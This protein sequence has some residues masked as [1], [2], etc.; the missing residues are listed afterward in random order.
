MAMGTYVLYYS[1]LDRGATMFGYVRP[2]KSELKIKTF[3]LYRTAYCGLC[4]TVKVHYGQWPRLL[5][6]YDLTFL[7]LLIQSLVETEPTFVDK[8]CVL[9]PKK[10]RPVMIDDQIFIYG[11][12]ILM[13]LTYLKRLDDRQDEGHRLIKG[14][15]LR[16]YHK[17]YLSA[18]QKHHALACRLE[19][20]YQNLVQ[21]EAANESI[22]SARLFG[23]CIG[24]IFDNLAVTFSLDPL[25]QRALEQAGKWLGEW[26]YWID[27]VDD[28][29]EDLKR[30]RP[31][32]L[33]QIC[34]SD[35]AAAGGER[36]VDVVLSE[37]YQEIA[38]RC[39]PLNRHLVAL[40]TK[41]DQ[42]FALLP[43]CQHAELIYNIIVQGL[44]AVRQSVFLNERLE[45]L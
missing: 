24:L 12:D 10:P 18:K 16:R 26:I 20:I 14:F 31:N 28:W 5:V 2:L 4:H 33:K 37:T 21:A 27:A 19:Q 11:A 32:A 36:D 29:Q 35:F 38:D 8:R 45:R 22:R 7:V 41:L 13:L 42:T 15:L 1:M 9:H 17:P 6:S 39:L 43:Y 40:E 30:Q 34:A 25:L 3:G 23:D 44:P